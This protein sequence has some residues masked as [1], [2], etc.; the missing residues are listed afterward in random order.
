MI[1]LQS[2]SLLAQHGALLSNF[3]T[4][5]Y[6]F[7]NSCHGP[8]LVNLYTHDKFHSIPKIQFYKIFDDMAHLKMH[9]HCHF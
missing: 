8:S 1:T 3:F 5:Q 2:Y 9:R 4:K 6:F 7:L